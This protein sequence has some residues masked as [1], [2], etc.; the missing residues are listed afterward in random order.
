[1]A[2]CTFESRH[3]HR[4]IAMAMKEDDWYHHESSR[5]SGR[6]SKVSHKCCLTNLCMTPFKLSGVFVSGELKTLVCTNGDR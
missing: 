4:D 3:E 2:L 5:T 1:M 6:L